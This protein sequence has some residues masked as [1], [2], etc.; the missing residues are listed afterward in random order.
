MRFVIISI[1]IITVVVVFFKL[2]SPLIGRGLRAKGYKKN[3]KEKEMFERLTFPKIHLCAQKHL[4][5]TGIE[6]FFGRARRDKAPEKSAGVS[7]KNKFREEF[8]LC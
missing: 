5:T 6:Q 2:F 4:R 8:K 7:L 3:R 1:F